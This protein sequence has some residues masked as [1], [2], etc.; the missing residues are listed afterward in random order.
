[1]KLRF[2]LVDWFICS[3]LKE[4]KD[5]LAFYSFLLHV[6]VTIQTW[7]ILSKQNYSLG[8]SKKVVHEA[9]KQF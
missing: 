7:G 1:M 9:T 8:S 4:K 3:A 5:A 6:Q 2:K